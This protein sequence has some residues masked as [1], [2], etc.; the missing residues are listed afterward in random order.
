MKEFVG[1]IEG[2]SNED[3]HSAPGLSF[4]TFKEFLRSPAHY[5]AYHEAEDDPTPSQIKG[6]ALHCRVLEPHIYAQTYAHIDGP[7]NRN[8]WKAQADE[9]KAAGKTPLGKSTWESVDGME[10]ALQAHPEART[11]VKEGKKEVAFFAVDPVTGVL[12]KC[13][14][15]L[16]LPELKVVGDLKTCSDARP[17]GF[18]RAQLMK[19]RY[20]IQ[21]AFYLRVIS[22]AT[23]QPH[24]EHVHL[25]VEDLA[26]H[27]VM[28]HAL[29]D[30]SLERSD[31]TIN[32]GL[33]KFKHCMDTD[34]WPGLPTGV[35]PIAI[36]SWAFEETEE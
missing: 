23:V 6:S 33:V 36:P 10:K 35:N 3:Y 8:P 15:D 5:K 29:D 18:I 13:K 12:M 32:H 27:G 28:L 11:M 1:V 25:C 14:A 2:M 31:L 20:D 16:W 22:L 24:K 17:D 21:S 26:P 19:L 34:T 4:T 30:A 9:A 7:M